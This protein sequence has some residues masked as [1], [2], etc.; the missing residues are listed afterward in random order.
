M[1]NTKNWKTIEEGDGVRVDQLSSWKYF[2][3]YINQNFSDTRDYIF[4]GQRKENWGLTP[5]L[6]RYLEEKSIPD[7]AYREVITEHYERFKLAARGRVTSSFLGFDEEKELWAIGQHQGLKTP[8]LDWT[9]SPFVAAY[10]AFLVVRSDNTD[11][12]V[13]FALSKMVVENMSHW[14]KKSR[15]KLKWKRAPILEI[16]EPESNENPN[17]V[18]QNGLFTIAEEFGEIQRWVIKHYSHWLENDFK[19]IKKTALIKLL[20]PNKDR[21]GFLKSL[22]QMNINH[23]TLFPNLYGASKYC[24]FELEIQEDKNSRT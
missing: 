4:R 12:R 22:N 9:K 5:T 16:F 10:F 13:V 17:L 23:L 15:E 1:A 11:N 19:S 6:Y 18:N 14:I 7:L 2:S 20:I 24:N 8:F 21:I 3:E